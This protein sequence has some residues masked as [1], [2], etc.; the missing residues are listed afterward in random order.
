MSATRYGQAELCSLVACGVS[1]SAQNRWGPNNPGSPSYARV[2]DPVDSDRFVCEVASQDSTPGTIVALEMLG[3]TE[4]Q[5]GFLDEQLA[6]YM[7]AAEVH[8][9]APDAFKTGG[10]GTSIWFQLRVHDGAAPPPDRG[11]TSSISLQHQSGTPSGGYRGQC[12]AAGLTG[13]S[14]AAFASNAKLDA[15]TYGVVLMRVNATT[16]RINVWLANNKRFET[17][18]AADFTQVITDLAFTATDPVRRGRAKGRRLP[19]VT[20]SN[21]DATNKARTRTPRAVWGPWDTDLAT[22]WA[23]RRWRHLGIEIG[24]DVPSHV[25][26]GMRRLN[27]IFRYKIDAY[28]LNGNTQLGGQLYVSTDPTFNDIEQQVYEGAMVEADAAGYW[29]L[30]DSFDAPENTRL[31]ARWR[32]FNRDG[33]NFIHRFWSEPATFITD[34]LTTPRVL[35]F[36][37]G[38]CTN[39]GQKASPCHTFLR[40]VERGAPDAIHHGGDEMY[41]DNWVTAISGDATD[42]ATIYNGYMLVLGAYESEL[43]AT[44]SKFLRK[45]DDHEFTGVT[46][47]YGFGTGAIPAANYVACR[48]ARNAAL[49]HCLPEV[50]SPYRGP[51]PSGNSPA[52]V[53]WTEADVTWWYNDTARTRQ[54]SLEARATRNQDTGDTLGATQLAW[55]LD[56]IE[57]C[58]KEFLIVEIGVRW[59]NFN[60]NK[61]NATM[62][63]EAPYG[64]S[65]GPHYGQRDQIVAAINAN[66]RIRHARL[67]GYDDHH[68]TITNCYLGPGS[69]DEPQD[70]IVEIMSGAYNTANHSIEQVRRPSDPNYNPTSGATGTVGAWDE[71]LDERP[72]TLYNPRQGTNDQLRAVVIDEVDE[73]GRTM[74]ATVLNGESGDTVATVSGSWTPPPGGVM[75]R[76]G[77]MQRS[78][79]SNRT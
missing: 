14:T 35:T 7:V 55:A 48:D 58:T 19:A 16:G 68:V 34:S 23:A 77:R 15:A 71:N 61:P 52:G 76:A 41:I 70:K 49:G 74:V 4:D 67:I 26:P 2:T 42:E 13:G 32:V 60:T 36:A 11:G 57:N 37:Y 27:A 54:I 6:D 40:L 45:A 21:G 46:D 30:R 12:N 1:P 10:G 39:N 43:L 9:D 18:E 20:L 62:G 50:G 38:S 53:P 56:L 73:G 25:T 66:P 33:G 79:R 29:V 51:V 28:G 31:Y 72:A 63:T 44:Q 64:S 5:N 22:T 69:G 65:R 47:Y 59:S 78:N 3:E 75:A 8:W 17:C 24:C